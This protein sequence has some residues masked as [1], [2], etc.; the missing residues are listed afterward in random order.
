M[1]DEKP[2]EKQNVQGDRLTE[3]RGGRL[4]HERRR[5]DRIPGLF[6]G[7]LLILVGAIFLLRS[8]GFLLQGEWWQYFLI[9]LGII[10]LIE[11]LVRYL[12]PTY[13][14]SSFGRF[15]AG[16]VLVFVGIAFLYGVGQWWPVV[17][18]AV[19]VIILL[20]VWLRRR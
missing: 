1:P 20:A 3:D 19:G 10:F 11:A 6:W 13:R 18:I 17:L 16:I 15:I 14:Y 5:Q 4:R 9:G 2:E 7:L 12:I 8:Q